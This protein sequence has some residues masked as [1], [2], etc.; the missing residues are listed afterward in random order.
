MWSPKDILKKFLGSIICK[1]PKLE[2]TQMLINSRINKL[3]YC[4]SIGYYRLSG[5]ANYSPWAKSDPLP[6]FANTSYQS[7]V[8]LIL[9]YIANSLFHAITELSYCSKDHLVFKAN[10]KKYIYMLPL[11]KKFANPFCRSVNIEGLQL[12]L[13]MCMNIT[14]KILSKKKPPPP[15]KKLHR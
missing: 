1:T 5:S 7:T 4:H 8:N 15:R 2:T 13:L 3:W 9:L 10:L 11:Q 12:C 6:V 14:N